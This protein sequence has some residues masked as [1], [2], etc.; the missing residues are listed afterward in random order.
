[1]ESENVEI[2]QRIA[3]FLRVFDITQT[4][5][6]QILGIHQGYLNQIITGKKRISATV[7]FGMSKSYTD[8]DLNWLIRGT[9]S[10]FLMP[11]SIISA[12]G[13]VKEGGEKY[14][15]LADQVA[16]LDRRLTALEGH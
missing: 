11:N 6:A 16:D 12:P 8:L 1:M 10:M 5:L 4:A 15:T 14:A 3:E 9:G 2:G 7:I 13:E